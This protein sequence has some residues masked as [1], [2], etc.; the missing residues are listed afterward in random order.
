MAVF[1]MQIVLF[2]EYLPGRNIPGF[3][4]VPSSLRNVEQKKQKKQTKTKHV[5]VSER[6]CIEMSVF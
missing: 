1:Q 4:S 2:V 3:P 5:T 6:A